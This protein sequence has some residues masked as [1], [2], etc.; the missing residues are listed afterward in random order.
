VVWLRLPVGDGGAEQVE[1]LALQVP[2]LI[3]V[4]G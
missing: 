4:L 3:R 1:E 2:A